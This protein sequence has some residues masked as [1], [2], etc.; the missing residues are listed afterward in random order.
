MKKSQLGERSCSVARTLNAV[1]DAWSFLIVRELFL[2]SRRFEE[3][4]AQT[5]ASPTIISR[6]LAQLVEHELVRRV[7]YQDNPP[8]DEFHLTRKGLDLW[9]I[10]VALAG[11]GDRWLQGRSAPPLTLRHTTCGHVMRPTLACS[12][13]GTSVGAPDSTAEL[14]ERF[15]TERRK[16]ASD[17]VRLHRTRSRPT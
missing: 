6:R 1:G 15:G 11:F 16:L 4:Q 14:S 9:P 17:F 10:I 8:R 2:G 13:C 12:E 3:F 5:G 7:P